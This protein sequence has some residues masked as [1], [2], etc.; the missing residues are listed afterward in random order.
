MP[1]RWDSENAY[2]EDMFRLR[3]GA[4]FW[5]CRRGGDRDPCR[6]D[7]FGPRSD[8]N[9]E[10]S[11]CMCSLFV[12]VL[13]VFTQD[14]L[15]VL[16]VFGK[17]NM[18]LSRLS[19][20]AHDFLGVLGVDLPLVYIGDDDKNRHGLVPLSPAPPTCFTTGLVPHHPPRSICGNRLCKFGE[21]FCSWELL[22][23]FSLSKLWLWRDL[24]PW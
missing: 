1:S 16:G 15:G 4:G 5:T 23:E 7:E 17:T 21:I 13:C 6:K 8:P 14:L 11:V 20:F 2:S 9:S 10:E 19:A 22:C 24:E 12:V 3:R 18:S